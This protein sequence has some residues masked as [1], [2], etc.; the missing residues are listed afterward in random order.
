MG[1]RRL[2]VLVGIS[3]AIQ[4]VISGPAWAGGFA[5]CVREAAARDL[6]VKREFQ[7]GLRD[8]IVQ[9][10]P[11]FES[12]ANV[13]M[14]L[15]I[16]LAEARQAMLGYLLTHDPKRIDTTKGIARFRNFE[17]S[18]ADSAKLMEKNSSYRELRG[19]ISTLREQNDAHPDWPKLREYFRSELGRNPDFKG[20]MTRFQTRQSDVEAAVARCSNE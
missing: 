15:Q 14:T 2:A 11:E 4:I 10:R 19:R 18:D 12:L 9:K 3:F 5:D 16:M 13:N 7:R 6:E 17:W 8:L 20:L 1:D